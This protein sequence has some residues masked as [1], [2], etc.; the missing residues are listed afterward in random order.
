MELVFTKSR[1][2]ATELARDAIESGHRH[3]LAVGGDGTN[4]EVINGILQQ[5]SVSP[6]EVCYTLLPIGTGNDWIRTM[7]I[8]R[9]MDAWLEM[10][11]KGQTTIQ[12]VGH[13]EYTREGK[14]EQ[15]YFANVAGMSFDAYVARF[16]DENKG[17]IGG[18]LAYYL[19]LVKCLA[20]FKLP[21]TR[22]CAD[23]FEL[24]DHLYTINAGIGRYSGGG[25]ELVPHA[26]TDDG[27]LGLTVAKKLSKLGVLLATPYFYNGKI[28]RHPRVEVHSA[29]TI[30]VKAMH[31]D[32]PV[33]LE[34]DGEFLGYTPVTFSVLEKSLNVLVPPR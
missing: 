7:G 10:F 29:R 13:V 9:E 1:G 14:V 3:I 32:H 33:G 17:F 20:K 4:N 16:L 6:L 5:G 12:D 2:H 19:A 24:E 11:E 15:R 31:E 27:L 23:G 26:I 28:E 22:V 18:P 30:E 21:L 25:M 8:P 34:V